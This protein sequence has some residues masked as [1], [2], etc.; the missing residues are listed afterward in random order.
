MFCLQ[1]LHSRCHIIE[2]V[3]PICSSP[4]LNERPIISDLIKTLTQRNLILNGKKTN[5]LSTEQINVQPIT[6]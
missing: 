5:K 6:M 4:K 3:Y 1:E 2:F